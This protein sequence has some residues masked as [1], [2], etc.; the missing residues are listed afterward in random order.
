MLDLVEMV[1]QKS[2]RQPNISKE[3]APNLSLKKGNRFKLH[4]PQVDVL[5]HGC[6]EKWINNMRFHH[7]KLIIERAPC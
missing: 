4:S 6:P 7:S 5:K 3:K 2:G 1:F